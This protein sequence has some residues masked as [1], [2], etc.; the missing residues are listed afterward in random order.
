MYLINV[1]SRHGSHAPLRRTARLPFRSVVR[2]GSSTTLEEIYARLGRRVNLANVVECNTVQAVKTSANKLL[3]KQA[4]DRA[5]VKTA[6][7]STI[8]PTNEEMYPA[9]SKHIYGSRGTGNDLHQTREE[10]TQHMVGKTFP[11]YIFEKFYNFSREYRLHVTSERCFYTCRKMLKRDTP[12]DKR[13][14]RNDS[15]CVWILEDNPEFDKPVNWDAIVQEAVK[16]LKAVGLDIGGIDV[17]VQ[18]ATDGRGQRRENPE[19]IILETNSAPSFGDITLE[20][21]K[22]EIPKILRRKHE[23]K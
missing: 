20:K 16:A 5:G 13:W 11:N 10:L 23:N 4:F 12:E 14:F 19:F 6:Q 7:W 1:R 9:V 15:N 18:S 8:I 22:V 17:R 21:Y 3:M 2:L